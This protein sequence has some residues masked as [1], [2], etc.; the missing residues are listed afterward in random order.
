MIT[1]V[2]TAGLVLAAFPLLISALEHYRKGFEPLTGWWNFRTEFLSFQNAII[3]Q[4]VR[5]DENLEELLSSIIP[6]EAEMGALLQDPLGAAWRCPELEAKLK[7]R[8]PSSYQSYWDTIQEMQGSMDVLQDK[9][10]TKDGKVRLLL[11]LAG[12]KY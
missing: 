6:S 7:K 10:H 8:L 2:E 1:G 11:E 9:L 5:F 12:A 4:K 3:R